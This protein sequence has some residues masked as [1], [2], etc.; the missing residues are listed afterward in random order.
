MDKRKEGAIKTRRKLI[1]AMRELLN[2]NAVDKINIEDITR[3]AGVA[4]GSFYSHFNR[5]EDIISAI[6]MEEYEA[7][8][9]SAL[10]SGGTTY[11]ML[12]EY[13]IKSAEIIDSHTL[14]LAQ[15]W[16]KCVAAPIE[17]EHCGVDKYSYDLNNITRLISSGVSSGELIKDASVQNIAQAIINAYYGAVATWCITGGK[18]DLK[19]GING[20]CHY[21]LSAIIDKYK[22]I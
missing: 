13:L 7:A 4:K 22:K 1:E 2:E 10:T 11:A 15:N 9:S 18:A 3:R 5:K 20:F 6:A 17:G 21:A 12:S 14:V 19:N 16:L 8:M